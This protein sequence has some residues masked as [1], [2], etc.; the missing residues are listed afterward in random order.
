MRQGDRCSPPFGEVGLDIA[1]SGLRLRRHVAAYAAGA[2]ELTALVPFPFCPPAFFK[3]AVVGG[4]D[5]DGALIGQLHGEG[6]ADVFG[7]ADAFGGGKFLRLLE[8]IFGKAHLELPERHLA[9]PLTSER[10]HNL[11]IAYSIVKNTVDARSD[12][13][14][15]GV[16]ASRE[17]PER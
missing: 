15:A 10:A 16:V 9:E 5:V 12:G 7:E 1:R 11:Y 3:S 2:P 8:F 13:M 14:V 4:L 6:A 17:E